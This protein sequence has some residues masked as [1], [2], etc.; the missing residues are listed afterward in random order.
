MS[1]ISPKLIDVQGNRVGDEIFKIGEIGGYDNLQK[2]SKEMGFRPYR[3]GLPCDKVEK[4]AEEH[5]GRFPA[6][7]FSNK[8]GD[9]F[10]CKNN[11]FMNY[12]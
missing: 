3:D 2:K 10:V 1:N 4:V 8:E 7:L 12:L 9:L 5:I 11:R 6:Q